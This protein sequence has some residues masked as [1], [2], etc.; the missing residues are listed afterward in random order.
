MNVVEIWSAKLASI[1]KVQEAFQDEKNGV[2]VPIDSGHL[3]KCMSLVSS[4]EIDKLF[5]QPNIEDVAKLETT[6]SAKE[7][8]EA[9]TRIV[10][11]PKVTEVVKSDA[12]LQW[13]AKLQ[14]KADRLQELIDLTI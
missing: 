8:V 12:V 13:L 10:H 6:T 7:R 5:C 3:L 11:G 14:D 9:M 2:K 1:R 4:F